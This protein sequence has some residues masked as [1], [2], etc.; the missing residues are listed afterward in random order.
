VVKK[1]IVNQI[2]Q[3]QLN[4]EVVSTV[5]KK[6]IQSKIAQ[7]QRNHSVWIVEQQDIQLENALN[8]RKKTLVQDLHIIAQIKNKNQMYQVEDGVQL[9]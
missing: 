2:V 7:N 9:Q 5:A 8:Q 6:V 1:D 3:I 4:L